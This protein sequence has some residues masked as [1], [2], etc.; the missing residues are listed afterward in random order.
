MAD[1]QEIDALIVGALYGELDAADRA[2]L[3]SHLSSHPEDRAA[4]EALERTRATVRRGLADMPSAEPSPAIS[5]ILLR[6]AGRLAPTP[7]AAAARE[8]ADSSDGLWS[9]FLRWARPVA[10]H[11]AFAGA[12]ALILV[13]GTASALWLRDKGEVTEPSVQSPSPAQHA[14]V[15]G[16]DDVADKHAE[17]AAPPALAPAADGDYRVDLDQADSG[18]DVQRD[19][20]GEFRDGRDQVA[21]GSEGKLAPGGRDR[22]VGKSKGKEQ[23]PEAAGYLELGPAKE[24]PFDIK[25]LPDENAKAEEQKRDESILE[26]EDDAVTSRGAKVAKQGQTKKGSGGATSPQPEPKPTDPALEEWAKG[27]HSRLAK[28]VSDGKCPE[29]GRLGA[30]IKDR[31]PEYYAANVANDRAIRACKSYI[32][33]QAKKKADKNYKSRSQSNTV[34]EASDSTK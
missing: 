14:A 9:R 25:D 33:G 8:S 4:L 32:E 1:R 16:D 2:R 15:P 34:D 18:K 24:P 7:R 12:A 17:A 27:A 19:L 28:L 29:A 5:T 31:A 26:T 10:M 20:A 23:R 13:A 21:M 22:K 30:E 11:P 6:E 3:E